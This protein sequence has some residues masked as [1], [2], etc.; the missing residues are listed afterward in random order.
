M[1]I[2]GVDGRG[3]RP[4][5]LRGATFG[6]QQPPH[7]LD[8]VPM[9]DSQASQIRQ[10]Q[11]APWLVTSPLLSSDPGVTTTTPTITINFHLREV[12]VGAGNRVCGED[13]PRKVA[14]G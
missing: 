6:R 13:L 3:A 4:P 11:K 10:S 2:V 12:V 7:P 8:D 1:A 5:A 14:Q 9:A